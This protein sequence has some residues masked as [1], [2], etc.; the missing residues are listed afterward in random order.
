MMIELS[1]ICFVFALVFECGRPGL[2]TS[3]LPLS[4]HPSRGGRPL[5]ELSKTIN[6]FL[7]DPFST[8]HAKQNANQQQLTMFL[9]LTELLSGTKYII[10]ISQSYSGQVQNGRILHCSSVKIKNDLWR[11]RPMAHPLV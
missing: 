2:Q 6:L 1:N 5:I 11:G 10:N 4:V 9:N 7:W 3:T 8:E